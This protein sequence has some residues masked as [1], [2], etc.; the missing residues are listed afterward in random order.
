MSHDGQLDEA[1][2][3]S[4]R[5]LDRK[6]CAPGIYPRIGYGTPTFAWVPVAVPVAG[7][8]VSRIRSRVKARILSCV[9]LEYLAVGRRACSRGDLIHLILST[10]VVTMGSREY[11]APHHPPASEGPHR[12][13]PVRPFQRRPP[14]RSPGLAMH[15]T[16]ALSFPGRT[17]E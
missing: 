7:V 11:A 16:L 8:D 2:F 9:V 4:G 12:R 1:G 13:Y 14:F 3:A 17:P 6:G 5:K 15:L 10:Q